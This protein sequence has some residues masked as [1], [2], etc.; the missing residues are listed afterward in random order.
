MNI[1]NQFI[2]SN[3]INLGHMNVCVFHLHKCDNMH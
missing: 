2:I 1:F 3:K